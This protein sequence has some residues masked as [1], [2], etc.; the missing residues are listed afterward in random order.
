MY[1]LLFSLHPQFHSVHWGLFTFSHAVAKTNY[2]KL[3]QVT[4]KIVLS[5]CHFL[6]QKKASVIDLQ[7]LYAF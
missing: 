3:H 6:A 7:T 2:P 4:I 5:S 1:C